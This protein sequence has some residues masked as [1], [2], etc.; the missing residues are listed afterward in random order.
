MFDIL[1]I[2]SHPSKVTWQYSVFQTV[3][4]TYLVCRFP[5]HSFA[6]S[7][8]NVI[9]VHHSIGVSLLCSTHLPACLLP[10]T[11][12]ASTLL[13]AILRTDCYHCFIIIYGKRVEEGKATEDH[14]FIN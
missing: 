14:L 11:Q 9:F 2:L 8:K 12:C 7:Q 1:H 5:H 10:H 13:L 4:Q 3:Q 6:Y